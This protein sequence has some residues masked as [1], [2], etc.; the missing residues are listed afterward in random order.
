MC[1]CLGL[2]HV[3]TTHADWFA[4][5]AAIAEFA[6]E[7][8]IEAHCEFIVEFCLRSRLWYSETLCFIDE[9]RNRKVDFAVIRSMLEHFTQPGP[10]RRRSWWWR[11]I[12]A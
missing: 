9:G 3:P 4:D 12:G 11:L 10:K 2:D 6:C 8:A 7:I 5:V 1:F